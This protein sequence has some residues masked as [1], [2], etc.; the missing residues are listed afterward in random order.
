M[1][2]VADKLKTMEM[3]MLKGG[4]E[5]EVQKEEDGFMNAVI[6]KD[7]LN[8]EKCAKETQFKLLVTTIKTQ[9]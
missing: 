5:L 4:S 9:P 2:D 6:S 1:Y 7:G 3:E 8:L